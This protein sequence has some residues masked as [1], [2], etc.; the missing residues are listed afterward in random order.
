MIVVCKESFGRGVWRRVFRSV[1]KANEF[2]SCSK[3]AEYNIIVLSG[4]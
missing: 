4:D 1:F 3:T 2:V